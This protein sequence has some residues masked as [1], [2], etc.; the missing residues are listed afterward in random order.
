MKLSIRIYIF[1]WSLFLAATLLATAQV[2]KPRAAP[3]T[4]GVQAA[5]APPADAQRGQ[6]LFNANCYR[7]HQAPEALN[8]RITGTVVRHMRVRANLSAAD[9]R[10]ILHFLNP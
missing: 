10:D 5:S 9:E 3:S 7:C 1:S 2:A 4:A 8:P 6:H